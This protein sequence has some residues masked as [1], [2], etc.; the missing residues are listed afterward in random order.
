MSGKTVRKTMRRTLSARIA[1]PLCAVLLAGCGGNI[2]NMVQYQPAPVARPQ[3]I[4]V[5]PFELDPTLVQTDHGLQMTPGTSGTG[6]P[7]SAEQTTLALQVQE[8]VANEIV[9]RL[10]S[11][12]FRAI[13]SGNPATADQNVLLVTGRFDK[14]D[15]GNRLRR[16]VIGFGAGQSKIGATV[17][18]WFQPAGKSPELL[19]TYEASTDSGRMPGMAET[20]GIGAAAGRL[21]ESAAAGSV[22]HTATETTRAK[23]LS[24]ARRMADLIAKQIAQT[25]ATQ[26]L[27]IETSTGYLDQSK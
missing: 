1:T 24:D 4:Y 6:H 25:S 15:S 16:I 19:E 17:Q 11:S 20:L 9:R 5:Y 14:V 26:K 21:A 23:P 13:R 12:G 3:N 10:Q 18:V 22:L 2:T 7:P 27:P 8:E